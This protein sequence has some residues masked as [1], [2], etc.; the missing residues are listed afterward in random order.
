[1][2]IVSFQRIIPAG[3]SRTRIQLWDQAAAHP[4]KDAQIRMAHKIGRQPADGKRF[5]VPI[6]FG[7]RVESRRQLGLLG[8]CQN[9]NDEINEC[10]KAGSFPRF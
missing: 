6:L 2:L 10:E 8:I 7:A 1:M 5:K 9:A 4:V 3:Q